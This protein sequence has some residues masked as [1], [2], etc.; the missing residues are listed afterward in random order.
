MSI[1]LD[2]NKG[3]VKQD[4]AVLPEKMLE[5]LSKKE[6]SMINVKEKNPDTCLFL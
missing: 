1:R 5:A 2:F 4:L 3:T 6:N